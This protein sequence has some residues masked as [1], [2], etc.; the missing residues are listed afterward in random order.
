M[1]SVSDTQL[2]ADRCCTNP[3]MTQNMFHF[4]RKILKDLSHNER[5]KLCNKWLRR[6]A[7][8]IYDMLWVCESIETASRTT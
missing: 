3:H 8:P 2:F 1:D 4:L 6:S 7:S 5:R